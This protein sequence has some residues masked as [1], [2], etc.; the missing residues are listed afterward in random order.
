MVSLLLFCIPAFSASSKTQFK[1]RAKASSRSVKVVAGDSLEITLKPDSIVVIDKTCNQPSDENENKIGQIECQAEKGVITAQ[2]LPST[3]TKIVAGQEAHFISIMWTL[4]VKKNMLIFE[5]SQSEF[6][7][8]IGLLEQITGKKTV[9]V[10]TLTSD[11]PRV[12]L[13]S[14][15]YGNQTNAVRDQSMEMA[16]DFF[17]VCSS[18]QI[19][20]N[21]QK[22]DFTVGLNHIEMGLL[23][24]DNQV[25]V[26][27]K[28]G[29]LISGKE[30]GSIMDGVKDACALITTLWAEHQE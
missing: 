24:R 7:I 19:T 5:P 11:P 23:F 14:E 17:N 30:G 2:F 10:D 8:V 28:D 26:Y 27:N 22:A 3:I 15:S 12:I 20:I 18:I 25:E 16:K 4:D 21:E 6:T 13:R 1:V 29:D 9:N